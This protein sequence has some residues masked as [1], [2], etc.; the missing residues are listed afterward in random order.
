MLKKSNMAAEAVE[1]QFLQAISSSLRAYTAHGSRSNKKLI[2]IHRW[3]AKT[4]QA[5]LGR[6][7]SVHGLGAGGEVSME[8]K[9]YPKT[10][11]I[12]ILKNDRVVTTVSFK[13][14][15]SNYKQNSNN[16]FENM[17]GESANIKR[18]NVGFAHFLV[19]RGHTPYL[20]KNKGNLRGDVEKI[21]KLS[22]KNLAKYLKLFCDLDF[23]HKPDVLGMAVVDFNRRGRA[24][25]A[26]L[27]K[28]GFD[29][30]SITTLQNQL[31]I[32]VFI[33]KVI[34][35]CKLKS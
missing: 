30:K 16:Y 29:E 12:A 22:E 19:L 1:T 8:G 14:V 20:N 18:A 26:D 10:L 34:A 21:E 13:F 33:D 2:P 7:Y 23:P 28:L 24:G 11:D 32:A 25:F 35:L 6:A 9:Y 5:H 31:S 3:L 17:L 4:I 27:C 15:T